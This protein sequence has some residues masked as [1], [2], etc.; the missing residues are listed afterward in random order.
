MTILIGT[1]ELEPEFQSPWKGGFIKHPSIDYADNCIY[2]T[3]EKQEVIIFRFKD[4]GWVNDNRRNSY[5]IS[6]GEAG[7]LIKI[8]KS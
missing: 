5:R 2:A 8:E 3:F 7:I 4:Y 1:D 6:S